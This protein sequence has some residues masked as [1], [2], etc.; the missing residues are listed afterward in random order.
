MD[1]LHL[2]P[3]PGGEVCDFCTSHPIFK[4]YSCRNFL[5]P[6]SKHWVFQHESVGGW[7]ACRKCADLIDAEKWSELSD[8]AFRR[9]V[10]KHGPIGRYDEFPLRAQFREL[11]QLFRDHMIREA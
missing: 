8:R 11:H 4:S 3:E 10:K 7:A 6:W 1:I 5:V 9:F 2:V